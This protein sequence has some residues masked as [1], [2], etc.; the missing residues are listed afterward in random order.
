MTMPNNFNRNRNR[1]RRSVAA[2][3]AGLALL[4]SA[5]GS[6][7][8]TSTTPAT[9]APPASTSAAATTTAAGSSSTAA[10]SS[11]TDAGNTATTSAGG[12]QAPAIPADL[13][14]AAQKEGTVNLIALPDDWANY[15]GIL[16]SFTK[17]YNVKTTV[18]SPDASSADEL[19]AVDTLKGQAT[20]PCAV[21][22]GPAKIPEGV[23]KG[24]FETFKP[25]SYD[26]IPT[27]LKDPNGQWVAAYYG[28]MAIGT[29]TG[30]VKKAPTSFAD[31]KDPQYKGQIAL[32]GDPRKT[33]AGLA[34]VMAASLANGGSFDDIM[35][36][37]KFFS[38]LKKS[39][40][41]LLT[42]V[43]ETTM[44][45]GETP[46]VLDWTYNFPSLKPK[47][48]DAGFDLVDSVPTDGVYGSYYA[49]AVIKGCPQPNAA[50]LWIEHILSND[51]ALGYL[52]G[53]AVPARYAELVKAGLVTPEIAKNLPDA[54]VLA[55]IKFPTAAQIAN[56]NKAL[57]D[58]WGSMVAGS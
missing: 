21:D 12:A 38:E 54:G 33:G 31:L 4:A 10:G 40:N 57:T 28:V 25:S 46:I 56:A 48:K 50:K 17:K 30:L 5:C 13:I 41:L 16:A 27:D 22:I 35:P 52:Q 36:G 58:N 3:A 26:Q 23:S 8:S 39:G 1:R 49:Q 18:A 9:T 42:D 6:S 55:K 7:K 37:I 32:N 34:A 53:G 19:T 47:M 15:K 24:Y 45:S 29:N 20:Q 43:N 11:S 14:A 2:V 51:G 44:I